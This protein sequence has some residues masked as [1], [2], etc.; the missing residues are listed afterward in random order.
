MVALLCKWIY[1]LYSYTIITLSDRRKRNQFWLCWF[2]ISF[3]YILMVIFWKLFLFLISFWVGDFLERLLIYSMSL[4]TIGQLGLTVKNSLISKT[5][6]TVFTILVN[7]LP[8]IILSCSLEVW[9]W[10]FL[11]D[12]FIIIWLCFNYDRFILV[13]KLIWLIHRDFFKLILIG[14]KQS[15]FQVLTMAL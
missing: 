10:D 4:V 14:F 1:Y 2:N 6:K 9:Y 5:R 7:L 12:L 15:L 11:I 8:W 3:N 13:G